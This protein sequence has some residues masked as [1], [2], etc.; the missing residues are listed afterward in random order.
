MAESPRYRDFIRPNPRRELEDE[1]R[2]HLET[3]VEELI[4]VGRSPA[5]ARQ[6]ALAKFG[7][8]DRF[9]AECS[10][11]DR[12]RLGRRRRARIVDVVR[13][14]L[15]Y[16]VRGLLRRPAFSVSAILVLAIGVGHLRGR[17]TRRAP[18]S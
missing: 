16:A 14:D 8:V 1:M 18:R 6:E 11:S 9:I 13:Q 17:R 7:N 3:E 2:F 4:A 15:R 10:E 12:K 5:E